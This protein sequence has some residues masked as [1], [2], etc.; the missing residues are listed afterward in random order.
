MPK[1]RTIPLA[2]AALSLVLVVVSCIFMARRIVAYNA[3]QGRIT[4]LQLEIKTPE[5]LFASRPVALTDLPPDTPNSLGSV[6]VSYGDESLTLPV[7]IPPLEY[8]DQF[9]GLERHSD[10]L[11]VVRFAPLTGHNTREL[12]AAMEAGEESDRLV[13][14][15]KSVRPGVNPETWGRVWRKDWTFDFY[16][17]LP[18]GG[19][20][21]ERFAYPSV[22][23]AQQQQQRRA[24]AIAHRGGLP[25]LD[26]RS[27]QFQVADLLMPE[28]SAPRIIAGDSPLVAAGWTFPAAI[29]SVF[30]ATVGLLLAFAPERVAK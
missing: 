27:W 1:P 20:R 8:A 4:Y 24:E 17:F 15:T 19:F 18:E 23:S 3:E 9:P 26:T 7:S 13:L 5:F 29:F 12:L 25:Q 14:V 11:R 16:E 6:H 10:W 21:H 22:R 30:L 2:I 28:G